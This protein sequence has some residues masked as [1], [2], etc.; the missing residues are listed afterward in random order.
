M[1]EVKT[2][3]DKLEMMCQDWENETVVPVAVVRSIIRRYDELV[4]LNYLYE[5]SPSE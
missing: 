3:V 5:G 1:N 4:Q 2:L